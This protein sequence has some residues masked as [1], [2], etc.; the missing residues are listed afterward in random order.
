[1][2]FNDHKP[3]YLQ[4]SDRIFEKILEGELTANERI[5]SVRELG[6]LYGVNP[7]TV[8]RTYDYLQNNNII[9][10]KRGVGY[11]LS[12]DAKNIVIDLLRS[13]FITN[14]LPLIKKKI[15][16]LNIDIKLLTES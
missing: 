3:I 15:R 2:E 9:Y 10:N 1:M 8:M 5:L 11:F 12:D 6:A 16:L 13:E 7:N 14:E 4:I